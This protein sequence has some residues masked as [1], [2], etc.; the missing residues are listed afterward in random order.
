[1][2]ERELEQQTP[3][4]AQ[5][6]IVHIVTNAIQAIL[7]K[8]GSEKDGDDYNG[9][10]GISSRLHDNQVIISISDDGIGIESKDRTKIFDPFFSTR[11]TGQGTGLGL[12]VSNKIIEEH[13]GKIFFEC[14]KSLTIFTIH[15]PIKRKGCKIT[16]TV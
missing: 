16:D 3:V 5:Q 2:I 15:L 13:G 7:D 6:V 9:C 4:L 1:M 11:P 14:I 12:S 10:L 8:K